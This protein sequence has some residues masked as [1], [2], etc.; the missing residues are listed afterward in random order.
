MS[1]LAPPAVGGPDRSVAQ[2]GAAGTPT[3]GAAEGDPASPRWLAARPGLR[4]GLVAA[5][6]IMVLVLGVLAAARWVPSG[7]P[8]PLTGRDVDKAVQRGIQRADQQRQQAPP[9]A[10]VV[11]RTILPSL[12][13]IVSDRPSAVAGEG[14]VGTGVLVSADG[15][16]LTALHVV[17]GAKLIQVSYADGQRA[18][19]RIESSRPETDIAVLVPYGLPEVVVPAVL[20]GGAGVGEPVFAVGNPLG[21][22]ATLTAGVVSATGRTVEVPGRAA[23]KDLIQFD[24]A[25][26][27]GSSGG[28]LL[29]RQGQVVGIVTALANPAGQP[30]F[31]GIGFAVPIATAGGP[32]I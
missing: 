20:G 12:V 31:V 18:S 26:N 4:R 9:D 5:G 17:E 2:R 29:N 27:P 30:F 14:R 15:Q 11:Y 19:A 24:A 21:L 22:Q 8:A 1:R 6:V 16:I 10:A 7:G 28:P 13:T 32:Q 23:L 25:V 3:A